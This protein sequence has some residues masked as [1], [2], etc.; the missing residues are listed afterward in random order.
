VLRWAVC[1]E[2]GE[3]IVLFCMILWIFLCVNLLQQ[4]F[5]GFY[6]ELVVL[7]CGRMLLVLFYSV[8]CIWKRREKLCIKVPGKTVSV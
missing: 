8:F 2:K 5:K 7:F 6:C 4:H 1:A 3:V